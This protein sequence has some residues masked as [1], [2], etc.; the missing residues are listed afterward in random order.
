VRVSRSNS[1]SG[2]TVQQIVSLVKTVIV[3]NQMM[4]QQQQQQR[5]QVTY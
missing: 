3:K 1:L 2:L 4:Q 5:G